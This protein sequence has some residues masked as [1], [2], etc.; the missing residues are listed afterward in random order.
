MPDLGI[1]A[2][3][4]FYIGD[5]NPS[6]PFLF[7]H[8]AG[9]IV[10]RNNFNHFFSFK[11]NFLYGKI[12][13]SDAKSNDAFARNRNLSFRSELIEFSTQMEFNFF[14]YQDKKEYFL[15][16]NYLFTGI[17]VFH[18][19]PQANLN[20]TWYDLQGQSTEG[21]GTIAYPGNKKYS[22]TQLAFPV[23]MGLKFDLS[24]NCTVA[25]EWGIRKTFTDY[26]DDVSTAYPDPEAITAE[27]SNTAQILSDRSNQV[28]GTPGN[29]N[30][31]RG[32]AATKDWYSFFGIIITFNDK[33]ADPCPDKKF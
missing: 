22:R 29:A 20:G 7:S 8:P 11:T 16:T 9:G 19:N 2:G 32:F 14:P 10:V 18:F 1:F 30:R 6:T 15:A 33:E 4:S 21:Q 26:I 13:G 23:G 24:L 12:S 25:L 5:L 17:S 28:T 27:K 3:G 31:Q